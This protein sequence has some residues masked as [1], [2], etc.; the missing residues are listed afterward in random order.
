MPF[1]RQ[2][3][4]VL[5]MLTATALPASAQQRITDSL[6]HVLSTTVD[7][8]R[9]V[10]LL[11]D[12]KDLNEDSNLNIPLSIQLFREAAAIEDVYA[13]GVAIVPIVNRYAP[14]PEREDSLSYYIRT[15]RTAT[16]GKPQEGLAD[17]VE[18]AVGFNRLRI[19]RPRGQSLRMARET[20]AWSDSLAQSPETLCQLSKR[21]LLLGYADRIFNLFERGDNRSLDRQVR[22]WEEA[23][24]LT[25]RMEDVT[26]RKYFANIIFVGLSGAYNHLRRYDDQLRLVSEYI[27]LLDAFY[28][29]DKAT[30][31]RRY[32]YTDNAYVRPYQQLIRGALNIGRRDLAEAHFDE[33]RKRLLAAEGE[34][35]DRNR[36]YLYELGYLMNS[37]MGEYDRSICYN[38]SL[39][40][41]ID[42]GIGYYRLIPEKIYQ[43]NHDRS[44]ILARAGRYEEALASYARTSRIQDSLLRNERRERSRTILQR[45]EMDRLKLAETRASIRN[46]LTA[47]FSFIALALLMLGA[48]IY[49]F[50]IWMHNRR[51]QTDI[52]LHSRKAQESE[53]MKS[54]FVNRICRSVGPALERI[55]H[56]TQALMTAGTNDPKRGETLD[57]IRYGTEVLLSTLDNMLEA[58]NLDSLTDDLHTE[59]VDV[60]E[61]CRSELLNASRL[62][63]NDR[64]EYRIEAAAETCTAK[65]HRKYFA[66]VIRALLDN[67]GKAT[68]SGNITLRYT[69]DE[70]ANTLTV[71]ITDTGCGVPPERREEIF[72]SENDR[73][74][75]ARGLSLP[76]CRVIAGHLR[77]TIRLDERYGPGAR[78]IFTIPLRP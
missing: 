63:R 16:R 78:F 34:N 36:S 74:N 30:G 68:R 42:R 71:S 33:L 56:T 55:D 6:Q 59:P 44:Q 76:L 75:A 40:C 70:T 47:L 45:H 73:G 54:I 1:L 17:Y 7:P 24:A 18:M 65:T 77:G 2:L 61:I 49:F 52:L 58:A 72:R 32:L 46:H 15:L 60:D 43:I 26:V 12:L 22:M 23:L 64:V 5:C 41:Q 38:D 4:P 14:Y 37:L 50:R 67:A 39:L 8:N 31:R 51:M 11:L 28:G 20:I 27:D 62:Q 19:N 21:L 66:F 10:Q 35:L 57:S 25:R 29:A 9:R 69:A 3:L 53:H 13:L 48:G